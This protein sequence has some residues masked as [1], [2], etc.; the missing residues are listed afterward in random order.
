MTGIDGAMPAHA[1]PPDIRI[2]PV[3][4]APSPQLARCNA[5]VA[6]DASAGSSI[7]VSA[8][9]DGS[10]GPWDF[11]QWYNLP[12]ATPNISPTPTYSPNCSALEPAAG[13]G[14][15][16]IAVID[17]YNDPTVGADLASYISYF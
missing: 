7:S 5:Y 1:A 15:Q 9:P 10:H 14:R 8:P 11:H 3:C 16:T 2:G 17:A 6:L 12:C 13:Y 4:G